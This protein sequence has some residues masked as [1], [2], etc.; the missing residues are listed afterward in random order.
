MPFILLCMRMFDVYNRYFTFLLVSKFACLICTNIRSMNVIP[1]VVFTP[2]IHCKK[3]LVQKQ[4]TLTFTHT[5]THTNTLKVKTKQKYNSQFQALT[6]FLL[7]IIHVC[8]HS[9]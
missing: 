4:I 3:E 1:E 2:Q 5:H 7:D 9:V 6:L 8:V